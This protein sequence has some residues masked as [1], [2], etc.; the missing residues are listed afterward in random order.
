MKSSKGVLIATAV[1]GLFLAN[2]TMA[3][4]AEEKKA[5]GTVKCAGGNACKGHGACAGAGHD[6]A[7][8]NECKGKGM[9]K[10]QTDKECTEKGGKVEK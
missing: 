2:A 3:M 6:C 10:T 1:A 4:A 9:V 8:K 5:E 7:G